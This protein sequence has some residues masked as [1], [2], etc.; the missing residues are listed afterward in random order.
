M[1]R[2]IRASQTGDV[3]CLAQGK[4]TEL[5][6][7]DGVSLQELFDQGFSV[8]AMTSLDTGVVLIALESP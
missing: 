2:F 6:T 5:K 3:N 4:F 8:A 1:Y 7:D